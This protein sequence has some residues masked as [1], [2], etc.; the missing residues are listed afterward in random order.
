[1]ETIQHIVA[2]CK[3]QAGNAYIWKHNLVTVIG[4]RNKSPSPQ[5]PMW[6]P[7]K[8]GWEQQGWGPVG[9]PVPDRQAA[10]QPDIEVVDTED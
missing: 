7:T 10:N 1:M 4:Y 8:G 9:V 2:G 6:N 5:V 3:I